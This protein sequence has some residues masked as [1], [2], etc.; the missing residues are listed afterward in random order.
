[1]IAST[2]FVFA[3]DNYEIRH[4][5]FHGN[6]TL[7]KQFLLDAM[8]LK[9]VSFLEKIMTKEERSLYSKEIVNMDMQR[10]RSNYQS[11]GFLNVKATLQPLTIN[12]KRKTV[13][14][15]IDIEEGE[16]VLVDTVTFQFEKEKLHFDTD[17]L[18]KRFH[19]NLKLKKGKR[20]RDEDLNTDVA[21][22]EGALKS[23]GHAYVKADYNLNLDLKTFKTG[24]KYSVHVGPKSYVGETHISGNKNVSEKFIRKQLKYKKG[25]K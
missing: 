9:E 24:I 8:S 2:F 21:L 7:D 11:E 14:L 1:M 22:I 20:F 5:N 18:V 25:Q 17:S 13:K 15:D 19:R 23:L 10:L 3:Q 6:K 4:I 16:P 12:E